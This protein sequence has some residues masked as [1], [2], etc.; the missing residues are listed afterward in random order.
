MRTTK[1]NV[2]PVRRSNVGNMLI[3]TALMMSDKA[4]KKQQEKP[5]V[6]RGNVTNGKCILGHIETI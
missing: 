6:S 1:K 5:I 4:R 3:A 2:R